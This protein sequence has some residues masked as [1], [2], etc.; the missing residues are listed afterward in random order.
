MDSSNGFSYSKV[1]TL[2]QSL[3]LNYRIFNFEKYSFVIN[4]EILDKNEIPPAVTIPTGAM[5]DI[6]IPLPTIKPPTPIK[7]SEKNHK[8]FLF[9]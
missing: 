5:P 8:H 4:V 2:I 6:V 3:N 7:I 9:I 1:V